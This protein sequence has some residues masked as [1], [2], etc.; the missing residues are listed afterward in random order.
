[1]S[2]SSWRFVVPVLV[3]LVT[4]AVTAGVAGA[5]LPAGPSEC[6]NAY[7]APPL[8]HPGH[9][10]WIY[11]YCSG[12]QVPT[13]VT[14]DQPAH[15]HVRQA[16]TMS[17]LYTPDAG[18]EGTDHF[19]LR[20]TGGGKDWTPQGYDVLSSSTQDTP[21]VCQGA[22]GQT[23]DV[24]AG[25]SRPI[26]IGNCSD[27]EGDPLTYEIAT[28]PSHGTHGAFETTEYGTHRLLFAAA[29]DY[30]GPD[31][32]SYRARDDFG[33][34]SGAV[35][36]AITI[37]DAA[38]NRVP[39][40]SA[41]MLPPGFPFSTA[42]H[43]T[44]V[45]STGCS[46]LDGDPLAYTI[47]SGPAHGSVAYDA[48]HDDFVYTADAGYAGSDAWSFSLDDGHGGTATGSKTVDVVVGHDPVCHDLDLTTAAGTP[49][50]ADLPCSD[51]DGDEILPALV[52]APAH[53]TLSFDTQP[54][55]HLTYT[56][57]PGFSGVDT[58]TMRATD[59]HGGSSPAPRTLTF[60]VT[61]PAVAEHEDPQAPADP[62]P[63]APADPA[64]TVPV[65]PSLGA[66]VVP[67]GTPA[68]PS[69]AAQAAALLGATPKPLSLG[70]GTAAQAFTVAKSAKPGAPLA[71][72]FCPAG[73]TLAIDGRLVLGAKALRL[74]HRTLKVG[75]A[76]PGVIRL[77]LT[78]AQRTS[79]ARAKRASV[80]LTLKTTVGRRAKTVR[81][82]FAIAP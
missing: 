41:V 48:Q 64:P 43:G 49:V 21:P 63:A 44:S 33:Q 22:G 19:T 31:T 45:V 12:P 5:V 16:T 29:G 71:V 54:H 30:T 50:T 28:E 37:R 65:P 8:A 18:F 20:P 3:L 32:L 80:V 68:P 56:P 17:F 4:L 53:G 70:L 60:T 74:A 15:G 47:T 51:G 46:D 10:R 14:I 9:E 52:G 55:L 66:P 72:V 24:R 25:E 62:A 61:A 77:T 6:V 58:A 75:A 34:A 69:A 73:C 40:C 36:V 27:A 23:L 59:S 76:K 35:P 57:D 2:R 26:A 1:M 78:K 42:I 38:S 67:Q 82:S 11:L 7:A 79:V 39:T 13:A 81:R